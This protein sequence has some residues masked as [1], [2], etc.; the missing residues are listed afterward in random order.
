MRPPAPSAQPPALPSL[1]GRVTVPQVLAL[2]A[3]GATL[4]TVTLSGDGLTIGRVADNGIV[5]DDPA[6]FPPPPAHR[7][8]RRTRD[9]DGP[10]LGQRRFSGRFPAAAPDRPALECRRLVA[11]RPLSGCAC[12]CPSLRRRRLG[13]LQGPVLAKAG[14]K[15]LVT[16]ELGVFPHNISSNYPLV[17][18]GKVYVATSNGVDWSHSNIPAPTAPS[19]VSVDAETGKYEAEIPA[20]AKVSENIMHCNWSSPSLAV[21]NGKKQIIFCA[22][23]GFVYGMAP[24]TEKKK[25]DDEVSELA[26]P[27]EV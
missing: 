26:D 12:S 2:T 3:A 9:G 4:A 14:F 11:G 18:D 20:S 10:W 15:H 19:F 22:G 27:V 8:G 17:V 1:Y 7:L 25:V 24:A 21:V 6:I 5:L 23:D 13:R 16:V